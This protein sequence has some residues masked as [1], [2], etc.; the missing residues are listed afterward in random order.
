[1]ISMR[2]TRQRRDTF[3]VSRLPNGCLLASRRLDAAAAALRKALYLK[4]LTFPM[5]RI[6]LLLL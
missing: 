2:E 4:H 1:M 6:D 3:N 5:K